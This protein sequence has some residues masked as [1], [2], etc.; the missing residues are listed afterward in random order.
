M[1][2][3]VEFATDEFI[4]PLETNALSMPTFTCKCTGGNKQSYG[5]MQYVETQMAAYSA[6]Q[7]VIGVTTTDDSGG[8]KN[9]FGPAAMMLIAILIGSL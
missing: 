1:R 4:T 7:E 8:I 9:L 5:F 2:D 3:I 6:R